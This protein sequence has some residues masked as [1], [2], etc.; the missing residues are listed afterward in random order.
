MLLGG[1]NVTS[2]CKLSKAKFS[3]LTEN[4]ET[5]TRYFAINL[6]LN[7]EVTYLNLT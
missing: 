6:I 7:F 1:I 4:E 5:I 3:C 2:E